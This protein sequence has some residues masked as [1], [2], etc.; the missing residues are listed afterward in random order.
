MRTKRS[1]LLAEVAS[2][3]LDV[4]EVVLAVPKAW[5]I[6]PKMWTLLELPCALIGNVDINSAGNALTTRT[7]V[8]WA[9]ERIDDERVMC[10]VRPLKPGEHIPN[11]GG[12]L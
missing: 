9:A 11:N 12:S 1:I 3:M 2:N 4:R 10:F 5:P 7:F 8:V 6:Q